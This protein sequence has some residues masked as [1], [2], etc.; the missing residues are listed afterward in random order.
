MRTCPVFELQSGDTSEVFPVPGDDCKIVNKRD[1]SNTKVLGTD[2]NALL[3][4]LN[5]FP[6]TGFIEWD[7]Q[8]PVEETHRLDE[9]LIRQSTEVSAKVP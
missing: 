1:R 8:D 5:E 2:P 3:P 4:E 7:D 9:L 6:L